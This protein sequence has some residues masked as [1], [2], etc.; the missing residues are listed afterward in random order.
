MFLLNNCVNFPISIHDVFKR[1]D[2]SRNWL[3]VTSMTL[4]F[5]LFIV[6]ILRVYSDIWKTIPLSHEIQVYLVQERGLS[7]PHSID[8]SNVIILL[9]D[10]FSHLPFNNYSLWNIYKNKKKFLK[11][12]MEQTYVVQ[13]ELF[14]FRVPGVVKTESVCIGCDYECLLLQHWT[15]FRFYLWENRHYCKTIASHCWA[16]LINPYGYYNKVGYN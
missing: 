13:F 9:F 8:N 1:I 6:C 7:V 12:L 16:S 2:D 10:I 15:P 3:F 4:I 14:Y 11:I 5:L